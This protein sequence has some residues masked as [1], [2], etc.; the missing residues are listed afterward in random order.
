MENERRKTENEKHL[1]ETFFVFH[2]PFSV[3]IVVKIKK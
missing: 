3:S 1:V 2:F